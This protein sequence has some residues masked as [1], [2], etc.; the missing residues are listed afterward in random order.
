MPFP[1]IFPPWNPLPAPIYWPMRMVIP[2]EKLAVSMVKVWSTWDPVD[3]ADTSAEL[4]KWPT[5]K[6]STAP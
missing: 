6:R 4:A 5:I 3:T 2:M 1:A